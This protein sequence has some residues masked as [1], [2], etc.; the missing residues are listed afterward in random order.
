MDPAGVVKATMS[1]DGKLTSVPPKPNV[2]DDMTIR[3]DGAIVDDK[4]Q[5]A[6]EFG[7]DGYLTGP[8]IAGEGG[9]VK[10]KFTGAPETRRA[11]ALAFML[12]SGEPQPMPAEG[13]TVEPAPVP[14]PTPTP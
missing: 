6:V 4:G 5:V 9:G 12:V 3:D 11:L 1:A 2:D 13:A 8:L 7:A 10:I 14:A